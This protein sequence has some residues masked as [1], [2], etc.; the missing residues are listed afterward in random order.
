MDWQTIDACWQAEAREYQYAALELLRAAQKQLT[1]DDLLVHIKGRKQP[2]PQ[3]LDLFD[4]LAE[5]HN[6]RGDKAYILRVKTE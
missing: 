4:I 2:E 5:Y 6:D 3:D 1:P